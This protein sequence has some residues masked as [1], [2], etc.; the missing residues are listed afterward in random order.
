M[1]NLLDDS[2]AVAQVVCLL[3]FNRCALLLLFNSLCAIDDEDLDFMVLCSEMMMMLSDSR[4]VDSN[5]DEAYS[6]AFNVSLKTAIPYKWEGKN[7][8]FDAGPFYVEKSSTTTTRT[9]ANLT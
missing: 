2:D 3:F 6:F 9:S 8:P 7:S 5:E 4:I 1:E